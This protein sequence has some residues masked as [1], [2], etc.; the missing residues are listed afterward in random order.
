MADTRG[1]RTDYNFFK[2]DYDAVVAEL[3]RVNRSFKFENCADVNEK[4]CFNF[5]FYDM[6]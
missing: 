4:V 6:V 1:W 5:I 2:A 3:V